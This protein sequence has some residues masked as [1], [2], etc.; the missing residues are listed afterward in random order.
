MVNAGSRNN[1][2]LSYDGGAKE[3]KGIPAHEARPQADGEEERGGESGWGS[4]S[5]R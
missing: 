1:G 5:R 2:C 4:V 3:G